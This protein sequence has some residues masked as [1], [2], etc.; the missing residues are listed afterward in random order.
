MLP[1]MGPFISLLERSKSSISLNLL[2]FQEWILLFL[3]L[4]DFSLV[5]FPM[6][7]GME[8]YIIG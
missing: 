4:K 8:P 6:L 1:G 7:G 2:C 3:T 5:R